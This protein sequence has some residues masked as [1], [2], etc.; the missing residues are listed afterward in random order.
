MSGFVDDV[1]LS[2]NGLGQN[3]TRSYVSSSSPGGNTGAKFAV[4]DCLF[5]RQTDGYRNYQLQNVMQYRISGLMRLIS[6]K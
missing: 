4:Y 2:H 3:Q 1:M 5:V 6:G